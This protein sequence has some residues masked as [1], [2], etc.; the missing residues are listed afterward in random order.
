[1]SVCWKNC[2]KREAASNRLFLVDRVHRVVVFLC[3]S[4]WF[5]EAFQ[6]TKSLHISSGGKVEHRDG[7]TFIHKYGI[8]KDD[9]YH[10]VEIDSGRFFRSGFKDCM[11]GANLVNF[12]DMKLGGKITIKDTQFR[13]VGI[14]RKAGSV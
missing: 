2:C 4:L 12:F 1:L 14:L 7:S 11:I 3:I 10:I 8:E 6:N 9:L 5:S 13:V